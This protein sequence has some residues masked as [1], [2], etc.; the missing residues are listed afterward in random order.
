VNDIP[1]EKMVAAQ[2][3]R[4]K[5]INRALFNISNAVSTTSNL[6]QLFQSIHK[7]LSPVLNVNNFYIAIY[8]EKK[9]RITFPY[10]VDEVDGTLPPV[11]GISKTA[12]L[13]AEVIRTGKSILID[14]EKTI[15]WREQSGY[16]IPTCTPSEIWLGVPLKKRDRIIGV[17]TV[18]SYTDPNLYDETDQEVLMSVAGQVSVAI[19]RKQLEEK[20]QILIQELQN[21]LDD[22]KTLQ[23]IIP[24]CSHC[25]NIRDDKG[26]W[27]RLES[28][29]QKHSDALF[30]HGICPDCV[31][32]LYG[33]EEWFDPDQLK[34]GKEQP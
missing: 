10:C 14:K 11:K 33:D 12:S 7:A 3:S 31:E 29:I 13:S 28:Y 25:K 5:K 20:Q 24:I 32:K 16:S 30:S 22:V 2:L 19:D 21:A 23:G 18:Q 15:K 34:G 27:N 26:Y 1:P 9:D 6:E 4:L 17:I 8:N